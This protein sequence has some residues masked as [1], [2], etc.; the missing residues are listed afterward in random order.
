MNDKERPKASFNIKTAI[1]LMSLLVPMLYLVGYFY[2]LGYLNAFDVSNDFIPRS[3]QTYLMMSYHV[4]VIGIAGILDI[5][6]GFNNLFIITI[7]VFWIT[8][9][10]AILF[11]NNESKIINFKSNVIQLPWIRYLIFPIANGIAGSIIL[12]IVLTVISLPV[13]GY[14]VGKN[15]AID[16][17]SNFQNCTVNTEKNIKPNHQCTF[18]YNGEKLEL[19][20]FS[21]AASTEYIAIYTGD[22]TVIQ[23]LTG[24]TIEV[25]GKKD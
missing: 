1:A 16:I 24:R 14:F 19:S 8:G 23:H 22:K 13:M 6:G 7:V 2:E 10:A 3:I 11:I 9:I 20:G 21:V 18:V 4:G 5:T 12:Y 17:K 15:V 25:F